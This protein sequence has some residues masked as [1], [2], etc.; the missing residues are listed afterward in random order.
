MIYTERRTQTATVEMSEVKLWFLTLL[1]STVGVVGYCAY[2]VNSQSNTNQECASV[3]GSKII[4]VSTQ[5]QAGWQFDPDNPIDQR[6]VE[7]DKIEPFIGVGER[8]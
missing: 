3:S 2:F 8:H 6:I 1:I 5:M 7:M 4:D